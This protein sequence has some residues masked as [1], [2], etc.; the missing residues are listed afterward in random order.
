[1]K[2]NEISLLARTALEVWYDLLC[3]WEEEPAVEDPWQRNV[4]A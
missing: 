2:T 4:D 1:M 3:A